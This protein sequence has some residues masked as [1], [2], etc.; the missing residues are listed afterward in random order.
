M[1]RPIATALS[2]DEQSD[3]DLT[4]LCHT[5]STPPEWEE[6]SEYWTAEAPPER[7]EEQS[8]LDMTFTVSIPPERAN[9]LAEFLAS[10]AIPF[11]PDSQITVLNHDPRFQCRF[12]GEDIPF[13]VEEINNHLSK[14]GLRPLIPGNHHEWTLERRHALLKLAAEYYHW[15]GKVPEPSWWYEILPDGWPCLAQEYAILFEETR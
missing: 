14:R 7:A 2:S 13:I 12:T 8:D 15:I 4:S 3:L 9:D 6:Q 10:I 1:N 5:V 11:D